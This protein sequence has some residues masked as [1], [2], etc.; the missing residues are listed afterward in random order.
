R[1][2]PEFE[3]ALLLQRDEVP[4]LFRSRDRPAAVPHAARPLH[5][6]RQVAEPVVVSAQLTVGAGTEADSARPRQSARHALDGTVRA[7][8]RHSRHPVRRVDRLLGLARL[9]PHAHPAGG[10]AVQ[11]RRDRDNGLHRR[12]LMARTARLTAQALAVAVV[13]ALL[14]LLVWRVVHDDTANVSKALGDGRHPTAPAFDLKRLDGRGRIDLASLRGRTPFVLDFW[15]SW[16][17][18][19]I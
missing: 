18:P 14:A 13:A 17:V 4:P 19:C 12:R 15:A 9:H 16:A 1:D 6:P 2:P 10:V 11:P 8:R 7:G 3:P 5:D